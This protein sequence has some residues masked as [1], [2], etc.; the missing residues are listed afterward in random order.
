MM[1]GGEQLEGKKTTEAREI[2]VAWL[3]EQG[4]LENE[5]E[6]TQNIGT[7]ERTGG[8]VEPLPKLQWFINVNKEIP[9]RGKSLKDIMR[10]PLENGDIKIIPDYFNKTYFNWI[11][12]LRDW[13][14][15]RQIWYGHRVPVWYCLHCKHQEVDIET[16]EKIFFVRHGET[17]HNKE[18]RFQGQLDIPLNETGRTQAKEAAQK[19]KEAHIDY[20][21]SSTLLRAKET[22]E[23]IQKEIGGQLII[24]NNLQE[25]AYGELEGMISKDIPE[26][27]NH[28][29]TYE[30]KPEGGESY[31]DVEERVFEVF[32]R[33]TNEYKGKNIVLVSHGGALRTLMKRLRNLDSD[34][35]L[36]RKGI[37]NAEVLSADHSRN[38]CPNCGNHLFEQDEDTLDTW[39]SSGMWTFSTLGWPDETEDLR[40][41]HPSQVLETGYEILFFW[42]ARMILMSGY[43]LNTIPFETIYLHG[44]VRDNK[45]QKMSKSL[46]NGIDPLDIAEIYGADA[47]RMALVAGTSPGTDSKISEDKIKGYKHFGNKIWNITRF[48]TTSTM[49]YPDYIAAVYTEKDAAETEAW[50]AIVKDITK[51]M[52]AYRLHLAIEKIYNY[53]WT[54]FADVIL[55]ESKRIFVEGTAEEKNSRALFLNT[56]LHEILKTV[57]PFMPFVT[58]ELWQILAVSPVPLIASP[59][60]ISD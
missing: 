42:V 18:G 28:S 2:V 50:H 59:W 8:I 23:I 14:I 35:M 12:N 49:Q 57:H 9:G 13:C 21:I 38:P 48:V 51:D 47:G 58:E 16:N 15:S 39:F 1:I 33:I 3:R 56:T 32:E 5:V 34:E 41:Y 25:R 11:G 52:D 36:S 44:T 31:K 60:V 4:L 27:L 46:G 30:W 45:G 22:A 20:I 40:I 7:A 19:L 55:E 29:R 17:D 37:K 26:L 24:E 53:T 43:A 6:V 10:D 54:T